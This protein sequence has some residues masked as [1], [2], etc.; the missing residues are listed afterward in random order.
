M[1]EYDTVEM[2]TVTT[3][4]NVVAFV[5]IVSQ[6]QQQ[7]ANSRRS[8]CQTA[9]PLKTL[10]Q[11]CAPWLIGCFQIRYFDI[12]GDTLSICSNFRHFRIQFE[13]VLKKNFPLNGF[14]SGTPKHLHTT[15]AFAHSHALAPEN[16]ALLF[17]A[18]YDHHDVLDL[19]KRRR[20]HL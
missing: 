12:F 17:D 20:N 19:L 3:R 18:Q 5:A 16:L 8:K 2:I 15:K 9:L 6:Q 4:E 7:T 1:N 11:T 14:E 13:T 10:P